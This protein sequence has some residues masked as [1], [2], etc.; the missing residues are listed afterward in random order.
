MLDALSGYVAR[1]SVSVSVCIYMYTCLCEKGKGNERTSM[2][3]YVRVIVNL[4]RLRVEA[5]SRRLLESL[6]LKAVR[7]RPV[8][9]YPS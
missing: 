7:L 8:E 6:H 3:T 9:V 1:R 4:E 2:N 5:S